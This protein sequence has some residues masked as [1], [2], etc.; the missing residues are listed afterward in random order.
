MPVVWAEVEKMRR[1]RA[2]ETGPAMLRWTIAGVPA[3][4]AAHGDPWAEG[5]KP[6][7]LETALAQARSLWG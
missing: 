2:R 5:W 4:L 1:S 3:L 6:H 7:R